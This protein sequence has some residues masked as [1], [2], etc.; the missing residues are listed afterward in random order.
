MST[1]IYRLE[2]GSTVCIDCTDHF[3]SV[4]LFSKVYRWE[5]HL[6]MGIT[7]VTKDGE[8]VKRYPA[9]DNPIWE[10]AQLWYYWEVG[11][12]VTTY[13]QHN[14]DAGLYPPFFECDQ[15]LWVREYNFDSVYKLQLS[16]RFEPYMP[17]DL[18]AIA[19]AIEERE[20]NGVSQ[21]SIQARSE[22]RPAT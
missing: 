21:Q 2:D 9:R 6:Y 12:P 16:R 14:P 3:A 20:I 1:G 11:S 7:F 5:G 22:T 13:L 17:L 19:H 8:E 15:N 18:A 10:L 4:K